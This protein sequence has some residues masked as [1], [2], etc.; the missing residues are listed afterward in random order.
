MSGVIGMLDLLLESRLDAEQLEQ[1]RSA[2]SCAMSLLALLNDILDLSK[3][4]AGRMSL[5]KVPYDVCAVVEGTVKTHLLKAQEKGIELECRIG[6]AVPRQVLGDP[7]RFRQIVANLVN[8]AVK[9]THRGAVRVLVDVRAAAQGQDMVLTVSDTGSGIPQEK[10]DAIFD[11]FTQADGSISRR[12]GGTGL[13]LAIT[14]RLVDIHAGRIEVTSE[15]GR[16]ST[17]TV[18]L[19]C[20]P[21]AAEVHEPG[22]RLS[23]GPGE[24]P[25]ASAPSRRILLVEDNPINQKVVTSLLRKRGYTVDVAQHGEEA[26]AML[27]RDS[28]GLVLM[29]VQMPVLDGLEATRRIRVDPQFAA[30]PIVAMT[31]HAMNGDRER[32]LAAGMNNYLAKPVDH[33]HLVALV[34]SYLDAEPPLLAAPAPVDAGM[35]ARLM[36]ADP[37]L[38]GQMVQLF[39]QLAPERVAMLRQATS[40]GDLATVRVE[41][42]KLRGAASSIAAV[43]VAE[44]AANLDEA[45]TRQDTQALHAGLLR[46]DEQIGQLSRSA[47]AAGAPGRH[48]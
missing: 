29:D 4:E 42:L 27:A 45:V 2:H 6:G 23:S 32:C 37:A 11:K 36:D 25:A 44:T 26:L 7:L 15:V 33:R 30:L 12:F 22:L 1:T 40:R 34:Q 28:Y 10:I 43:H 38:V 39:L 41:L 17:F 20:V 8:N 46:L 5:E 19:A 3:I 9:F 21:A 13:G 24:A 16:G 47:A 18:V 48:G 14:R 35:L 31:A